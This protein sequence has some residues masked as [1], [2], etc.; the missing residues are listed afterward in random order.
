MSRYDHIYLAPHYDDIALSCGGAIHQQVSSGETVLGITVCAAEPAASTPLSPFAQRLHESWGDFEQMVAIRRAEDQAAMAAL[1]IDYH[2]LHFTDCIYRGN[3]ETGQWYYNDVT[4][5]FSDI[6]PADLQLAEE[7]AETIRSLISTSPDATLYAPLT[8]GH[9]V[10]HQLTH[11]AAR[12]LAK[13]GWSV[14]FYE[15]YPYASPDY[16]YI[17]PDEQQPYTVAAILE[18]MAEDQWQPQL[19]SLSEADLKVK[20]DSIR[21]YASQLQML[22][23]GEAEMERLVREYGLWVGEGQLAERTWVIG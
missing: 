22:F 4:A 3:F 18:G 2:H 11:A 7:I 19:R 15:D 1:G 8:V 20:I 12:I 17:H 23:G 21:A 6:H 14:I 5:I 10:D 16:P 9:H 13:D